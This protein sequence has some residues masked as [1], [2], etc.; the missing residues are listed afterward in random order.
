[1]KVNN[2]FLMNKKK[3]FLLTILLSCGFSLLSAME[4]AYKDEGLLGRLNMDYHW[5]IE[6][7][8]CSLS[9]VLQWSGA[10]AAITNGLYAVTNCC[11]KSKLKF[12][13]I[14]SL[15]SLLGLGCME[16]GWKLKIKCLRNYD[17]QMQNTLTNKK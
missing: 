14:T 11:S 1:M 15:L 6:K 4:K 3:F 13:K 5:T 12:V 10:T 2:E 7:K 9:N 8:P 16:A 17:S